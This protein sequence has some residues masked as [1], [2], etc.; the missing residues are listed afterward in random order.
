MDAF[1]ESPQALIAHHCAELRRQFPRIERCSARLGSAGEDLALRHSL[2]LD[3]RLPQRQLLV[4]G[5]ARHDALAAIHAAFDEAR[6]RLA[7]DPQ[8]CAA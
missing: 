3:I 6:R 1:H 8:R 2:A 7:N 4:C 5:E